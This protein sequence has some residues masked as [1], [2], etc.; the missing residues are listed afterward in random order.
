MSSFLKLLLFMVQILAC[1]KSNLNAW[2]E[3]APK[4]FFTNSWQ[5]LNCCYII[6]IRTV[7]FKHFAG[8]SFLRRCLFFSTLV[9][10]FCFVTRFLCYVDDLLDNCVLAVHVFF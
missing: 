6:Y 2:P 3:V 10:L 4:I 5:R 8:F 7:T 9:H 1:L